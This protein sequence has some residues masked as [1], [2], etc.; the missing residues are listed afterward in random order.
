MHASS[1]I[2]PLNVDSV[3]FVRENQRLLN[4]VSFTLHQGGINII[5]G[6]NGAGKS[7]LLRLCNGLLMPTHGTISWA[8]NERLRHAMVFQRPIML[9]RSVRANIQHT[10]KATGSSESKRVDKALAR[11]RLTNLADRPARLLSG[12]EQQRLAI[13]RAW[14]QSPEVLF[15]DEPSSQLDPGNTRE[16]EAMLLSLA[17]DGITLVM[18]THDLGQARRLAQRIMFMHRGRLLED[19]DAPNFFLAPQTSQARAFL[20]GELLQ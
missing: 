5:I 10:L 19:T 3:S 8:R 9:R 1:S 6:P 11:F 4:N 20:A 13:A 12:G 17:A 16:I 7:L 14:S 2:L 18:T 15:L